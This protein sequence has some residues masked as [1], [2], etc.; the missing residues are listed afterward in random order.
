MERDLIVR[1]CAWNAMTHLLEC[2]VRRQDDKAGAA[3][4]RVLSGDVDT[5]IG[6][7]QVIDHLRVFVELKQF[8]AAMQR[9]SRRRQQ[10]S[11]EGDA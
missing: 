1:F 7:V 6:T 5:F 10:S 2:S 8:N 4:N 3:L 9:S 11:G